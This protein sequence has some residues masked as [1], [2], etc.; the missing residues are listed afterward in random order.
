MR[1]EVR[2][3]INNINRVLQEIKYID[4]STNKE[5]NAVSRNIK[6]KDPDVVTEVFEHLGLISKEISKV[7]NK[8]LENEYTE[9]YIYLS[10][11]VYTDIEQF[12]KDFMIF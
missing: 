12:K 5:E 10:N 8:G 3:I 11:K 6:G 7:H 4:V 1:S 9:K 2:D